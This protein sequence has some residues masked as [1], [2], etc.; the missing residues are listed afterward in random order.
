MRSIL[1]AGQL[2]DAHGDPLPPCIVMEKGES[3]DVWAATSGD[4]LDM[5]TGL[6]VLFLFCKEGFSPSNTYHIV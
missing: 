3:L 4:G 6:Q 1:E 2:T 5:V